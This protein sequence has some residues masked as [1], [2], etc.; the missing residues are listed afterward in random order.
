[1]T[2][3]REAARLAGVVGSASIRELAT[4]AKL[5]PPISVRDLI[6][7]ILQKTTERPRIADFIISPHQIVHGSSVTIRWRVTQPLGCDLIVRLTS[8]DFHTG[9]MIAQHNTFVAE[10]TIE[11]R[12]LVDTNYFL[13]ASCADGRSAPQRQDSVGVSNAPTPPPQVQPF[14]FKVVSPV[15]GICSTRL[16]S[17]ETKSQAEQLIK[18]ENPTGTVT[19]IDCSK[20]TTA[21]EE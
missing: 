10:S 16:I 1:V 9:A 12:P 17:A 15:T 2:T 19:N 3:V 13:D 11:D 4:R 21:C 5:R 20:L 18:A 7:I 14:C 8:R 6:R